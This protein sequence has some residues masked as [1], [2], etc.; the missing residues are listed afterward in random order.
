MFKFNFFGI[1]ITIHEFGHFVVAKCTNMY[2]REFSIGFGPKLFQK[3][4]GETIYSLRLLPLGG[5]N[6]IAGMSSKDNDYGGRGFYCRPVLARMAVIIA[7]SLAGILQNRR[8]LFVLSF[9]CT[10]N[11]FL[12]MYA[13]A[14][15]AA[16]SQLGSANPRCKA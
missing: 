8:P 4:F 7:G 3:K 14:Q 12:P 1:V 6:D 15:S 2:V 10:K 11:E 16:H 9:F 5:Y 13:P